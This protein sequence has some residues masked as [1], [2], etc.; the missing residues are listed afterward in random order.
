MEYSLRENE[1]VWNKI[2]AIVKN[3]LLLTDTPQATYP[4]FR[5]SVEFLSPLAINQTFG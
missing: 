3:R 1:N 5:I 4:F 2:L